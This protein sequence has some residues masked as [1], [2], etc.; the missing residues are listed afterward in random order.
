MQS[1][2]QVVLPPQKVC[3]MKLTEYRHTDCTV[4]AVHQHSGKPLKQVREA[5]TPMKP[6]RNQDHHTL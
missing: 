3:T 1:N 2:C 4:S 6:K 5:Y